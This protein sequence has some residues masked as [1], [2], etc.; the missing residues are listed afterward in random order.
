MWRL[1]WVVL[2][3]IV[4]MLVVNPNYS[5]ATHKSEKMTWQMLFLS[6]YRACSNYQYQMMN[7]YDL[8]AEKYMEMY[9]LENSKYNAKCITET[10][11]SSY[12]IPDDLDLLILI[13]DRNIGRKELNANDIGGFYN[14][15]GADKTK[16]HSIVFCDCPNF[17]FSD[18]VWIL[19]HEL[20]HFILYYK[21]FGQH[22]VEDM[23]HS[24]DTRYDSC[25]ESHNY[26]S[27][28][29]VKTK[30]HIEQL[31][32]AWTVMTPYHPAAGDSFSLMTT[33]NISDSSYLIDMQREITKWWASGK[34]DDANY[35]T[36]LGYM[37]SEQERIDTHASYFE[38][39]NMVFADG[40]RD[41][42]SDVTYYDM[43]SVWTEDQIDTI[44]SRIPFKAE[45]ETN[46]TPLPQ[47]FKEKALAW[48]ENQIGNEEY[49]DMVESLIRN[50][51]ARSD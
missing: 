1:R 3:G 5:Y 36:S 39:S 23:I 32:Y 50:E 24:M 31:G 13:Y 20:S 9:E 22:V 17:K 18:P 46:E 14:H 44:F 7:Q 42:K 6:S 30:L 27:C 35:A 43:S 49:F 26:Q 11:Y 33:N 12:K 4:L 15:V 38:T 45:S 47:W 29:P 25:I 28:A 48:A 8:I 21:G 41:K 34:I 16:N 19:S 37:V 2:V 40:P 51:N 10:K